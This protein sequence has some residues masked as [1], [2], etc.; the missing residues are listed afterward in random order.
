[1]SKRLISLI[2][3]IFLLGGIVFVLGPGYREDPGVG[4]ILG[5]GKYQ[6]DPHKIFRMVRSTNTAQI[7][8]DSIVIWDLTA[9]D[10]VTI[11]TTTISGDSAVAGILVKDCDAQATAGNT[12]AED[13]GGVNWTWL[14]TYG[15]SQVNYAGGGNGAAG[16]AMGTSTTAGE[17]IQ[18]NFYLAQTAD[19]VR[20]ARQMGI[21]GFFYD[22][23]TA[24]EDDVECFLILD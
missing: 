4:D 10:G 22:A 12:A 18:M 24:G 23:N 16:D 3:A 2:I 17:A 9:D 21:A 6:S 19:T 13:R 7:D 5:Q 15:E 14:Q 1:M 11:A 20:N 8:A